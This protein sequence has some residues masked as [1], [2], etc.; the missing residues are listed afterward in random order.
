M[1]LSYIRAFDFSALCHMTS[2]EGL[3]WSAPPSGHLLAQIAIH[4]LAE[5]PR[6]EVAIPLHRQTELSSDLL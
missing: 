6:P 1:L 5:R 3:N 4:Q 2:L